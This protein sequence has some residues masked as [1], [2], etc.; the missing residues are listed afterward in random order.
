MKKILR[1]IIIL[2]IFL[3]GIC[4]IILTKQK[5]DITYVKGTEIAEKNMVANEIISLDIPTGLV[6]KEGS[7]ATAKW[8]SVENA[9]YYSTIVYVFD[10]N[11]SLIG[12]RE[13]GTSFNE[14]DV[15]QEIT[16]ILG[17]KDY[18]SY[19]V[20]FKIKAQYID[21]IKVIDGEYSSISPFLDIVKKGNKK[22]ETPQNVILDE[23]YNI[24][25]DEIENV[26]YYAFYGKIRYNGKTT[27]TIGSTDFIRPKEGTTLN[28]KFTYNIKKA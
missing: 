21:S 3:L 9:N 6:W 16:N 25:F 7:T 12:E 8:N 10:D 2:C 14:L 5:K 26:A 11:D 18:N 19:H 20:S 4:G 13:T 28:G 1:L 23:D 15:Q 22:Y 17:E 27:T 24:T